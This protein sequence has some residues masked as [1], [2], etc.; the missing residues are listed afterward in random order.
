MLNSNQKDTLNNIV[1]G[2]IK[3][4]D[5]SFLESHDKLNP[6]LWDDE[7]LKTEIKT[8]LLKIAKEFVDYLGVN[9]TPLDIVFIGSMANYNWSESS[10]IDLHVI[11]DYEKIGDKESIKELITGK[12]KY[13]NET[14]NIKIKGI[15]I[16]LNAEDADNK[17][18]SAGVYSLKKD[19]WLSKPDKKEI[20]KEEELDKIE[21][22]VKKYTNMIN[23][24]I[25]NNDYE[26]LDKLKSQLKEKRQESL[27]KDGEYG[28]NNVVFKTLR[29]EGVIKKMYNYLRKEYDKSLSLEQ[30]NIMEQMQFDE[31]S[32]SEQKAKEILD[33]I[34]KII[35][36]QLPVFNE[37]L[38]MN[39]DKIMGMSLEEIKTYEYGELEEKIYNSYNKIES[40]VG[41]LDELDDMTFEVRSS[42]EDRGFTYDLEGMLK[43]TNE[44]SQ[45]INK[46]FQELMKLIQLSEMIKEK[47]SDN[48]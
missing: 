39:I 35:D 23:K 44:M 30:K 16:E 15:E 5:Y 32:L 27:E 12:S 42:Y 31:I 19:K 21:N 46:N 38:K 40:L 29:R 9:S 18:F 41:K 36:K 17:R 20:P 37:T 3:E 4:A 28:M 2:V 22:K 13:W 26:K 43:K 48:E 33:N 11:F 45:I 8:K 24:Y 34:S 10:D 1:E 6:K 25:K 7:S 14:H 47:L